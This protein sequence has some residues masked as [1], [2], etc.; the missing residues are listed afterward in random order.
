MGAC[1]DIEIYDKNNELIESVYTE[2]RWICVDWLKNYS[3]KDYNE[4]EFF[5]EMN[6]E[7]LES[8]KQY[9]KD[10]IVNYINNIKPTS[11]HVDNDF[12]ECRGAIYLLKHIAIIE[13]KYLKNP[14]FEGK[15]F[16]Y[17]DW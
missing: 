4:A 1:T 8:I 5:G 7:L 17:I 12:Y 10:Y 6:S 15:T 13:D 3:P 16:L 2:S 14:S 9:A 11:M